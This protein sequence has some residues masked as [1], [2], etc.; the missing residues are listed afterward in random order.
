MVGLRLGRPTVQPQERVPI[1]TACGNPDSDK[2][3]RH[4]RYVDTPDSLLGH[5]SK[6]CRAGSWFSHE[7]VMAV[8][9]GRHFVLLARNPFRVNMAWCSDRWISRGPIWNYG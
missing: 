8:D 4:C 5:G 2:G 9:G 1:W 3:H 7:A 6:S